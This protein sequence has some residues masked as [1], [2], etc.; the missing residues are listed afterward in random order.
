MAAA[1][2][3]EQL[4]QAV[5]KDHVFDGADSALLAGPAWGRLGQPLAGVRPGSA[6]EVSAVVK[7]AAAAGV[8][9][10]PWGGRTG[11]VDGCRADGALALSL[12]RMR[13]IEDIDTAC[14]TMTVEAGCVVEAA[15]DA[16]EKAGLFLPLD[17]GSR[18]SATIGGVISTNAGGNRVL[19]YGMTRDMVLGLEAVL[20]D[21]QVVSAMN[22]LIKN[23]AGY[24]IKQLFIGTEGTLGIVT[25]AVLRLRPAPLSQMTAFLGVGRF[26]D[27]SPLLR[28]LER[29]LGGQ[30]S[31]FEVMWPEFHRL[32][33][34]PP[35]QG[36]PVLAGEHA[37]YVLVE[38]LGG[39][40]A[41]DEARFEA[42]LHQA[43]EGG[44]IEDAVLAK[45]Q[46][47]RDR[48]W[49]LRDDV[50]QTGRDGPIMAF[51]VS[52]PVSAMETYVARVRD[53]LAAHWPDP[54]LTVFGHLGDGN[55]HVI[56]GVP[57]PEDREAVEEIVYSALPR[58]TGSISAE[59]GIGLQK[60]AHLSQSRTAPEIALMRRLKDAL[61]PTGLF[62]PGKVLT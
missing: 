47:E 33:T 25:R 8:P 5:G 30:L 42:A 16:A 51:D 44:L 39:D 29:G 14:G 21:G 7:I 58:L 37:F 34:T 11:L 38:A 9:V 6:D 1:D 23:N 40:R 35:A 52:L 31:A 53:G 60:K 4:R 46:A 62:N 18:G 13:D 54:R 17:L 32:V 59:H 2:L 49:A 22:H 3:L 20:A 19:R 57:E 36:R 41:A 27:L 15:A 56:A 61:D 26:A 50:R 43:L 10:V 45:S 28:H 12:E 48:M 55:L 24:D